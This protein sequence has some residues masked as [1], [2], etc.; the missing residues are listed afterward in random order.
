[1]IIMAVEP[2]Y[3]KYINTHLYKNLWC[4]NIEA[5]GAE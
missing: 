2:L 1:M 5:M 4:H 3:H